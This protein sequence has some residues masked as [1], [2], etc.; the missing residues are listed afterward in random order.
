[1]ARPGPYLPFGTEQPSGEGGGAPTA[2]LE[3]TT[4]PWLREGSQDHP[5][6]EAGFQGSSQAGLDLRET[7]VS[8]GHCHT[9]TRDKP[10]GR[11]GQRVAT[12]TGRDPDVGQG[13]GG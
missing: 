5:G 4:Q 11:A 1:M 6:R 2:G 12:P 7:P 3:P 8:Q 10:C 9:L 13:G